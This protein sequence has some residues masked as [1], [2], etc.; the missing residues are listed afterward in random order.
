V[1]KPKKPRANPVQYFLHCLESGAPIEGPL[2]V[3]TARIGQQ[4]VDTAT[5]SAKLRK[6]LEL[7]P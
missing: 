5:R 1:D 4:I 3:A 2:S 7:L 6:P